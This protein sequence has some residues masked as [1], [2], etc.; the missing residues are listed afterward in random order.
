[1]KR[2]QFRKQHLKKAS[3]LTAVVKICLHELTFRI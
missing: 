1:M 3:D 2:V